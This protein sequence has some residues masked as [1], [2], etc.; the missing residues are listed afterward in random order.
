MSLAP[1]RALG[2][3]E[4]LP[5]DYLDNLFA[6]NLYPLWPSLRAVL[7]PH[8]P[9]A[10]TVPT[11]WKYQDVRPLLMK[12]GELTPM[13][14]AE[15]RVLVLSNPGHGL[16][17]MQATP[18]MYLGLQLIMPG[19]LAP[20]HRHTPNAVRII[21]EG[22]GAFTG[23][24]GERCPMERGDLILTPS[25][26]WHEHGHDGKS[27]VTWLDVLDLPLI[28]GLEASY[29]EEGHDVK[30]APLPAS[31]S[32]YSAAGL[33]PAPLFERVQNTHPLIRFPWA[34]TKAGL[35][36]LAA[37]D[38]GIKAVQMAYVNP[39][40]GADCFPTI[41]FSAIMLRPGETL[42][43][44]ERSPA[45]VFHIVEGSGSVEIRGQKFDWKEAD[46]FCSPGF[47]T[48]SLKNASATAPA[49]MIVADESPV[50]KKLGL[51]E[52]RN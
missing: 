21:V 27:P 52:V 30:S 25:G 45:A 19:E 26:R 23:V 34:R 39:E 5:K 41:S 40:N 24:N 7:P 22:E 51:Y 18:V 33:A 35:Q 48:I 46:T 11:L 14:K 10:K 38:P 15:R 31:T 4:E 42:N 12:A 16:A 6:T 20:N 49:Y 32:Q 28:L 37:A 3:M 50:H 29:L 9:T 2:T 8:K 36:Q 17:N 13:E 1:L 44:P 47:S 43:I